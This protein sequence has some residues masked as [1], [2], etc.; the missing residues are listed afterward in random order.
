M[1]DVTIESFDQPGLDDILAHNECLLWAGQ[2]SYGRR[3][4]QP[5]GDEKIFHFGFL[6]GALIMWSTLPF[7]APDV[8]FSRATALWVYGA[9]T[10]GFAA[11]SF[12]IASQRQFVLH[13]LAYFVTD[14]RAIVCR[15]G[16]NWWLAKRLYV[17]SCPLSES[18]PYVVIPTNPFPSLQI[19]TL[20]SEDQVQPFGLGLSHPG[21]P[22]LRG[23]IT[24]PI[25]FDYIPTAPTVLEIID[26]AIKR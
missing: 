25:T 5:V 14:R 16:R 22:I 3:F 26:K 7:I 20:L 24:A 1:Q 19:G 15:R 17:V 11:F 10:I 2:P 4:F 18:Y 9:V 13:N 6:I 8:E 23:R 12:T 21:H